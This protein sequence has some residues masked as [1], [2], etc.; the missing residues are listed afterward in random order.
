MKKISMSYNPYLKESTFDDG[1]NTKDEWLNTKQKEANELGDWCYEFLQHLVD[2]YNDN[3]IIEFTGIERDCDSLEDAVLN[4]NNNNSEFK[5]QFIRH[6][7]TEN[8]TAGTSSSKIEKLKVL[9]EELCSTDCPF[10]DLRDNPKIK[11]SFFKALDNDFEIAVVATMSSGKSTLINA[12]LGQELLPA[13][14]EATTATLSYIHDDDEAKQFRCE[15]FDSNG[16][17]KEF[18]PVTLEHMNKLND[19][20]IPEIHLYGD[21]VGISSQ[22][23][24]LVLTDTPGPN[25]SSNDEHKRHTFKLIKDSKYKPMILYVLNGTQLETNDDNMLLNEIADAMRAGGRQA[26]DRFIF[27]LNKADEFDPEK[28]ESVTRMIEK[29]AKYLEKHGIKN[30]KIF[31]CSAYFAKIIR[32]YLSGKEF[33]RKEKIDLQGNIALF[34]DEKDMHFPDMAPLSDSVREKIN[35]QLEEAKEKNDEYGQ[36]LV[37]TGITAIEGAISEYLEKYALPA[38][39]TE[40]L[41]SFKQIID[42]IDDETK[43]RAALK[44][45]EKERLERAA[46][47]EI[48]QKQIE[49]GGKAQALKEKI[50]ALSV[51]SKI[52]AA[53]EDFAGNKVSGFID[54]KKSKYYKKQVPY[55]EAEKY[56]TELKNACDEFTQN[57][58]IDIENLVNENIGEEAEKYVLEYNNYVEELL[59]T[60]FSHDVK[61]ASILGSLAHIQFSSDDIDSNYGYEKEEI[62]GTHTETHI[63]TR[64][65]YEKETRS[66][67]VKESGV[68]AILKRGAGRFFGNDEWGYEYKNYTVDV[69]VQ[70]QYAVDEEVDD[71][72]TRHYINFA[73]FF[74]GNFLPYF[75]SITTRAREVAL[76]IAKEEETKLK[77][78]FMDS[79]DELTHKIQ[80]KLEEQKNTLYEKEQFEAMI[81]QN[82]KNIKWIT[83][84]K[85]H[86]N[87]ALSN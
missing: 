66:K 9:Y 29:T 41:H 52:R 79:F 10:A 46:A 73:G 13:R 42:D 28:G 57:F 62:V 40:A 35:K 59:G 21:I 70:R 50:A 68:V 43:E 23:L 30:P 82:E 1:I 31:P 65:E 55:Q 56:T 69:P 54:E 61:A 3:L 64:T 12:M 75:D 22:R 34:I 48:M 60:A 4:F 87:E 24:K 5:I 19:N 63:E 8:D 15:Y 49:N 25:N 58:A 86:L 36:A 14:N 7:N 2:K 45:N 18:N 20:C 72:E 80:R 53:Y 81:E 51:D 37:H 17:S 16:I 44:Q 74:E 26:S 77:E 76:E 33:T 83:D 38:K 84:F 11:E 67:K 85:Q 78:S 71:W 39:I 47:I 27:V 32:Q 6:N